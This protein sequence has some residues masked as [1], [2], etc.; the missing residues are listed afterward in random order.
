LITVDGAENVQIRQFEVDD[1]NQWGRTPHERE[2]L[3]SAVEKAGDYLAAVLPSG[4][5][6]GKIGIRYDDQPEAGTVFQFDVIA[7]FRNQGVGTALLD[8]AEKR[9]RE[10]G[11]GRATLAVED[12]NIDAMRLYRRRGYV[13]CGAE[14]SEWDQQVPDGTTYR[15]RCRCLLMQRTLSPA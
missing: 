13:V 5:I 15:Y 11:W 2:H 7:D 12:S 10:R 1:A 3:A 4:R 6:I 8:H 14:D 9:I